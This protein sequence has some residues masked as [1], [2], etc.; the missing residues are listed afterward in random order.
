MLRN[1]LNKKI[2]YYKYLVARK[3]T[4]MQYP[5]LSAYCYSFTVMSACAY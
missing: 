3:F 5:L 4:D 1:F 2:S